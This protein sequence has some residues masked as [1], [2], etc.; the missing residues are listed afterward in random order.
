V[1]V[2]S[3]T[4][5][6]VL[7]SLA[8]DA[9]TFRLSSSLIS[10][11]VQVLNALHTVI[12]L[13]REDFRIWDN[14][15]PQAIAS[16]GTEDQE[17]DVMLMLDVSQ[18]T[19]LIQESIKSSAVQALAQLFPRDRVGVIVFADEPLVLIPL[20][21]DRALVQA[22]LSELPAGRGGTELNATVQVAGRY[23]AQHARPGARRAIVMM[24]D[25]Q[26]YPSVSDQAVRNDLWTTNVVFNLLLFP[27]KGARRE[28]DVRQFAK[29]TGG[30]VLPYRTT[31]VPLAELLQRLRQRYSLLYLSPT[32]Q[33]GETRQLRVELSPE[34][35]RRFRQAKVR[36][37]TG[38]RVTGP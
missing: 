23:L 4:A 38:Y 29:A 24:S 10:V 22:K 13:R 14:G 6:F 9:V 36:A 15:A 16:F 8:Q 30:E 27:A 32:G 5:W 17:L 12:G 3:L 2:Y 20:T 31:G 28:A 34:A 33:P 21:A 25:N 11:D 7:A 35:K 26:G 37:R 18:S 1:L 19:G